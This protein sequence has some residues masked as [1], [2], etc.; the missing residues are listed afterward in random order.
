MISRHSPKCANELLGTAMAGSRRE[1]PGAG[2]GLNVN[3]TPARPGGV[4]RLPP[5]SSTGQSTGLLSQR[6]RVQVPS[7]GPLPALRGAVG[8]A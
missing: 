2:T 3:Q 6:L 4:C 5:R 1:P 8:F 7:W